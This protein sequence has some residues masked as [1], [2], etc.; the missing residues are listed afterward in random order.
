MLRLARS[1]QPA[2]EGYCAA[3]T[4]RR[5][6]LEAQATSDLYRTLLRRL[7]VLILTVW[8]GASLTTEAYSQDSAHSFLCG[9]GES[10]LGGSLGPPQVAIPLTGTFRALA[11]FVRFKDDTSTGS[12]S[13]GHSE[14]PYNEP[15]PTLAKYL[16]SPSDTPPFADSSLTAYFYEQSR[17]NFILYGDTVSYTTQFNE[18][19]YE[20]TS[21]GLDLGELTTEA[22]DWL[23]SNNVIPDLSI[24]DD[25]NDGYVDHIFFI[26]RNFNH[27]DRVCIYLSGTSCASGISNL[28][29]SALPPNN[30]GILLDHEY[31]GSYNIYQSIDPLRDQVVLL[32]HEIGHDLFNSAGSESFGVHYGAITGNSMPYIPPLGRTVEYA[33]RSGGYNLMFSSQNSNPQTDRSIMSASERALASLSIANTNEKWLDCQTMMSGQ[34]HSLSELVSSAGCYRLQLPTTGNVRELYISNIYRYH[35][36]AEKRYADVVINGQTCGPCAVVEHGLETTGMM[37]ELVDRRSTPPYSARVDIIPPDN[38]VIGWG[39]YGCAK[40]VHVDPSYDEI[41]GADMWRPGLD[42]QITPWTRPNIYGYTFGNDVP[43]TTFTSGKYA[44]DN[45]RYTSPTDSTILFE[46]YADFSSLPTMPVRADSWIDSASDGIT[47]NEVRVKSGV[48]L[49]IEDTN[50]TFSDNLIAEAGSNV[51]IDGADI[52]FEDD[53]I[54][55]AGSHFTVRTGSTLRFEP[56]VRLLVYGEMYAYEATFTATDSTTGWGGIR[57][58][59]SSTGGV[60]SDV[61]IEEV[62][63]IAGPLGISIPAAL[64]VLA[65]T[66]SNPNATAAVTL[67]SSTIRNNEVGGVYVAGS[68]Y[69]WYNLEISGTAQDRSFIQSNDGPGIRVAGGGSALI[70]EDTFIQEN[71]GAGVVTNGSGSATYLVDA[72]VLANGGVGV[73][74]QASSVALFDRFYPAYPQASTLVQSN[75]GGGLLASNGAQIAAGTFDSGS[76]TSACNN[77]I[78][79]HSSDSHPF[80]AQASGGGGIWAE[81]NYWGPEVTNPFDPYDTSL[82]VLNVLDWS[83]YINVTPLLTQPPSLTS[84]DGSADKQ[85]Q[86]AGLSRGT[87]AVRDAMMNAYQAAFEDDVPR[88]AGLFLNVL[89]QAVTDEEREMVYAAPAHLFRRDVP[90]GIVTALEARAENNPEARPWALR[91]LALIHAASGENSGAQQAAARLASEFE[92]TE[93]A[94]LG[95]AVLFRLALDAG[96]RAGAEAALHALQLDWP[97]DPVTEDAALLFAVVMESAAPVPPERQAASVSVPMDGG[98]GEFDLLGAYPNPFNPQTVVRFD[99]GARSAVRVA[100]YDLLGREV[101]VLTDGVREVGRHEAMLDGSR[102]ASG[103]YLVRAVMTPE[104][105]GATRSYTQRVL[106]MK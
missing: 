99:V 94:R 74:A 75:V 90:P 32:A 17:G 65:G 6:L 59:S 47:F 68:P 3:S 98:E 15:T 9:S 45:I 102:L 62:A 82:L 22:L 60:L 18:L 64:T 104:T 106:L 24:Y 91:A 52:T 70:G 73:E 85:G 71:S 41:Y 2:H 37:V 20:A 49:T 8:V 36:I 56:G 103:V 80:D 12:C 33:D 54:V 95:L 69:V 66:S 30:Y 61:I 96:D 23:T 28:S 39:H 93:H 79:N 10:G 55:E 100:V 19:D 88:A 29:Y 43:T 34:T 86:H 7:S 5:C 48:T 57:Y 83:S 26:I 35:N 78:R 42:R 101:A 46:Y 1:L 67:L 14:W 44:I 58:E 51:V 84:P 11:I 89:T 31:S 27:R 76:C 40:Y 50:I 77:Q 13:R 63:Q 92:G 105:G 72:S 4:S 81:S 38:S 97:N 87:D 53:L 21:Y 25:N 16:L